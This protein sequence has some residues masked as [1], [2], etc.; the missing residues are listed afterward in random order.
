[1]QARVPE[2]LG[3][4]RISTSRFTVA[5]KA[6]KIRSRLQERPN[7]GP[8]KRGLSCCEINLKQKSLT[9]MLKHSV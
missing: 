1:M 6:F 7:M 4:S 8:R 2:N 5:A 3:I 9:L